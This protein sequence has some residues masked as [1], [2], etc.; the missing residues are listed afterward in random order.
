MFIRFEVVRGFMNI[1]VYRGGS[2]FYLIRE[3]EDII[4]KY[5]K[6]KIRKLKVF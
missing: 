4:T 1:K 5:F 2:R 3:R 6:D